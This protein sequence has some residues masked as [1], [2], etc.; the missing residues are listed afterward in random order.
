MNKLFNA[1]FEGSRVMSRDEFG[2]VK[3]GKYNNKEWEPLFPR[4]E[5]K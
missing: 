2:D 1:M 3:K 4:R 5:K